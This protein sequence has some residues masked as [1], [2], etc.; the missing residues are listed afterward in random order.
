MHER[1]Q[2]E[3]KSLPEIELMLPQQIEYCLAWHDLIGDRR[4]VLYSAMGPDISTVLL[5]TNA[6]KI[7]GIDENGLYVASLEDKVESFWDVIS[8]PKVY[9]K[10]EPTVAEWIKF[11]G[12]LQHRKMK[13]YW[14]EAIIS[15]WETSK[16]LVLELKELGVNK[17]DIAINGDRNGL[18]CKIK[19][20]WAYPGEKSKKRE[21]IY[22]RGYIDEVLAT[23]REKYVKNLDCYYQKGLPDNNFTSRYMSLVLPR[24]KAKAAVAIG[25]KTWGENENYG[26]QIWDNLGPAFASLG[27][28]PELESQID[29]LPDDDPG[30]AMVKYGMKLHV[31]RR[32]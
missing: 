15:R 25:Y 27:V 18:F 16:L 10:W 24:L 1:C 17:N 2:K 12:D 20:N 8:T 6:E 26:E 19:F 23:S 11:N 7:I 21:L 5:V 14:D 9:P 4:K 32:G 29:S 31:F 30:S 22:L 13:G 28:N 3:A